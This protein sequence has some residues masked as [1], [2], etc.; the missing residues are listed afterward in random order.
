MSCLFDGCEYCCTTVYKIVLF[1][2]SN[3]LELFFLSYVSCSAVA[4]LTV[5]SV[6]SKISAGFFSDSVNCCLWWIDFMTASCSI[7]R[8]VHRFFI[9]CH[10][11]LFV[12]NSVIPRGVY[13]PN[14]HGAPPIL[15]SPAPFSA[16][17]HPH[18]P[19]PPPQTIF[20]HFI[21]NFVQFYAC[22]QWTLEAGIQG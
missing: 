17:P 6:T 11:I 20:G 22:F 5:G 14:N 12:Y 8:R 21:R 1:E 2:V 9:F 7:A 13:P 10:T 18:P 3:H 19:T 4:Y 15:T 16:T